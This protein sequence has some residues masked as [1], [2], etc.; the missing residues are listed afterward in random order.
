MEP[1]KI[2]DV[3]VGVTMEVEMLYAVE[4]EAVF[5]DDAPEELPVILLVAA[6]GP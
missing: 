5:R 4:V 3:V 6:V 2:L 1:V